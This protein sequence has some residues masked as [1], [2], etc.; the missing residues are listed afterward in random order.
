MSRRVLTVI[1]VL[2]SV[3]LIAALVTQLLWVRDAGLL[4]ADQFDNSIRLVLK[5]VVNQMMSIEERFSPEEAGIDSTFY[6]QHV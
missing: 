1:I 3:S 5:S 6:W 4:K 2:T